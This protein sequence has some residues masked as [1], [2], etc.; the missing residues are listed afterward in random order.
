ME[1][2][3]NKAP[4]EY[5]NIAEFN[6]GQSSKVIKEAAESN[7][8]YVVMKNGKPIAVIISYE[9]YCDL[10]NQGVNFTDK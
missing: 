9:K 3:A 10:V 1:V 7:V 5:R 6:R 8:P 2:S 4:L